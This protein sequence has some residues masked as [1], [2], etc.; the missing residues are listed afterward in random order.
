MSGSRRS[1]SPSTYF[2]QDRKNEKEFTRLKIQDRMITTAMGGVL[3]EQTD[4]AVFRRVLDVGCGTGGWL[5]DVAQ[6]YP[7]MSL[8]GI[9]VSQRM[10]KYARTQAGACHLDDRIEFYVMDA[11]GTLDFLAA[12]F[13][14]VNLRFGVSFVRT[15]DWPKILAELR[16]TRPGGVV[17]VTDIEAMHQSNS[18]ALMRLLEILQ[19]AFYRAGHLFTQ[20]TTGVTGHL[21]RLLDQYGCEQ[22]QVKVHAVK[23]QAGTPEG[24]AYYED[25]MLG[26][27]TVRPF[28]QKWGCASKDYEA[29]YQ[30]ALGEMRQPDFLATANLL[31]AWGSKP[32]PKSQQ[33]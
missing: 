32:R 31:T 3:A 30:Q 20:E 29:I 28:I 18:P 7:E 9:D 26:F 33:L 5:V 12:C 11:L 19:C 21:A 14:L 13:D 6:A 27:R 2:V 16:I 4:P 10:I 15:W 22:V 24:E 1:E 25:M 23:Y 17:R 8:V